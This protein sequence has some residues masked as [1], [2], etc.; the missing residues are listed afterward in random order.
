[1]SQPRDNAQD[2]WS[3]PLIEQNRQWLLAY[4]LSV[5]GDPNAVDDLVQQVFL[6][7]IKRRADYDGSRPL[8]AWLRGIARNLVHEYRRGKAKSP[9][10]LS[11]EALAELEAAAQA[12]EPYWADQDYAQRRLSALRHCVQTLTARIRTMLRLRYW[13]RLSSHAI[14]KR[15]GLQVGAVDM[16]LCRARKKLC[17]CVALKMQDTST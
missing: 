5:T 14:G 16:A 10:A 2:P 6:V 3:R 11:E 12:D 15:L 9:L 4:L 1:M 17:D 8:G 7:A 13:K